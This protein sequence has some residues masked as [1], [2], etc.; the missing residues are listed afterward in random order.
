[1]CLSAW[2]CLWHERAYAV[3]EHLRVLAGIDVSQ[4]FP[5]D[6]FRCLRNL[7]LTFAVVVRCVLCFCGALLMDK[8]TQRAWM[9]TNK[10]DP[11]AV[12]TV[13]NAWAGGK[14]AIMSFLVL[15][16]QFWLAQTA[17][18]AGMEHV[19]VYMYPCSKCGDAAGQVTRLHDHL[20]QNNVRYQMLWCVICPVSLAAL[21]SRFCTL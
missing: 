3:C 11:N 8:R 10:P 9:E 14:T 1:M 5:P 17:R 7:N 13:A 20:V 2:L 4:P 12:T 19:D 6:H 21:W 15:V 16:L 18:C